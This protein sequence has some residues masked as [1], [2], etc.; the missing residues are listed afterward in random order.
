MFVFFFLVILKIS[1]GIKDFYFYDFFMEI[2]E[3]I[4]DDQEYDNNIYQKFLIDSNKKDGDYSLFEYYM[5]IK[6]DF[7]GN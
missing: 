5:D 4:F 6:V 2:G 7:E 1:N 3:D